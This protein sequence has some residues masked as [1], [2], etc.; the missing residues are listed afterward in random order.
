MKKLICLILT[1]LMTSVCAQVNAAGDPRDSVRLPVLMYHSVSEIMDDFSITPETFE[2][3]LKT[4]TDFGYTPVSFNQVIDY[5][6]NGTVLPEKPILIT[7][8]DGYTN[9]YTYAFPILKRFGYPATIFT[10]GCSAGKSYYKETAHPITPH[11]G[12]NEAREMNLSRL[13]SIQCHTYDMHQW[14][15]FEETLPARE[16]ILKLPEE[17]LIDY[18][19]ILQNDFSLF[20]KVTEGQIGHKVNVVAYPSGRYDATTETLLRA[21]GVK[22]T[23]STTI[24]VNFIKKFNPESLYMLN[25][26]NMN[27]SVTEPVLAKW[28]KNDEAEINAQNIPYTDES[29]YTDGIKVFVNEIPV[30]FNNPPMLKNDTTM[31]PMRAILESMG[32]TVKWD[33]N[34]KSA[35]AVLNTVITKFSIGSAVYYTNG[36]PGYLPLEA[37]LVD[38]STYIPLRAI[39]ESFGCI[40]NWDDETGTVN[41]VTDSTICDNIYYIEQNGVLLSATGNETQTDGMWVT[42]KISEDLYYAHNVADHSIIKEITVQNG[43]AYINETEIELIPCM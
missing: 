39:A 36:K 37:M 11:F 1:L 18:T 8:D 10:I 7:F 42:E 26:Y 20:K 23:V 15:Q 13:I 6:Y 41:I 38:G 28:L 31:V 17:K 32:A 34:A 35:K 19:R 9:N 27:S 24:G 14:A 4:I 5:V 25:R 29:R 30:E 2:S 43:T 40:V 16:N 22:A 12:Y 21:M 3:S 33:D